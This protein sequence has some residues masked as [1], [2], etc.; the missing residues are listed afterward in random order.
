M[1]AR[2]GLTARLTLSALLLSL[3]IG[4]ALA[5]I[6]GKRLHGEEGVKEST[7]A[8]MARQAIAP[9]EK[10]H[11]DHEL[12]YPDR[13]RLPQNPLAPALSRFPAGRFAAC[14]IAN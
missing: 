5:D 1:P 4:T 12:E 9:P 10:E 3:S 8:I 2:I 6:P 11:P 14:S 13:S 7:A